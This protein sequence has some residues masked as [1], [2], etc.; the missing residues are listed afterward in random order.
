M[1][2]YKWWM[3][4]A[5][6][7]VIPQCLNFIC[8]HFGTLCLFHLH[9]QVGAC[10]M[11]SAGDIFG[12]LYGKRFVSEM[13]WAIRTEGDRE[14]G[15]SEYRNKLW[16]VTTYIEANGRMCEIKNKWWS[17]QSVLYKCC[18]LKFTINCLQVL[19]FE[20]LV[21]EA[22]SHNSQRTQFVYLSFCAS[23]VYNI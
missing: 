23:Q 17:L 1:F 2:I 15:G 20:Q 3:L 16:R 21:S 14:G 9:R 4:Y 12:V 8:G 22:S 7:W 13:A 11:N 5:F 6:F 19:C 10:R 18:I